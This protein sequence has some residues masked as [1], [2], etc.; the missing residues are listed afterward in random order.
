MDPQKKDNIRINLTE[1]QKKEIRRQTGKEASAIEFTV[2]EL[3][4]RI[5]PFAALDP[6]RAL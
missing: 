1:D 4:E 2:E 5:A 3:E 6:K